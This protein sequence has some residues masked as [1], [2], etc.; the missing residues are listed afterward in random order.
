MEEALRRSGILGAGPRHKDHPPDAGSL[1]PSDCPLCGGARRIYPPDGGPP[2]RCECWYRDLT[3]REL[4]KANLPNK[5]LHARFDLVDSVTLFLCTPVGKGTRE[6]A[7]RLLTGSGG[8]RRKSARKSGEPLY[9]VYRAEEKDPNRFLAAYLRLIW[10]D[11]AAEPRTKARSIILSGSPG[12]GKTYAACAIGSL[13]IKNSVRYAERDRFRYRVLY[14]KASDYL[15]L[16]SEAMNSSPALSRPAIARIH[17]LLGSG[18]NPVHLLIFD[19]AGLEYHSESEW[20]LSQIKD[21][22]RHRSERCLPVVMTTNR[23]WTQLEDLYQ[24]ETVSTFHED[25]FQVMVQTPEDHRITLAHQALQELAEVEGA[26]DDGLL[27]DF[28]MPDLPG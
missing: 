8:S 14:M 16:C 7:E 19:E 2:R 23:T 1:G 22:I 17:D 27:L 5:F 6:E 3:E 4:R 12:S 25:Y 21:L 13:L 20:A 18:D 26:A 11:L 10:R 9:T 28:T 24:E 15:R